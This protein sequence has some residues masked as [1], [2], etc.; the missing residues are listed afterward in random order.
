MGLTNGLQ[1]LEEFDVMPGARNLQQRCEHDASSMAHDPGKV[2]LP[3]LTDE[4]QFQSQAIA[5]ELDRSVELGHGENSCDAL[6][7]SRA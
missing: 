4:D 7:Q 3:D 6:P 2:V 1:V 5:E